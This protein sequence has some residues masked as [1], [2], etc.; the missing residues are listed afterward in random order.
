MLS[1]KK[2]N[3]LMFEIIIDHTLIISC[4]SNS[5]LLY[6]THNTL[7]S[8]LCY[9]RNI[10][11][12]PCILHTQAISIFYPYS[13]YLIIKWSWRTS[14][15]HW[16]GI[17]IQ[18]I[19]FTKFIIFDLIIIYIFIV[20]IFVFLILLPYMIKDFFNRSNTYFSLCDISS[21]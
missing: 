7:S 4:H 1:N 6:F 13:N 14:R 18:I 16:S 12:C 9:S 3:A 8:L 15:K 19:L 21:I 17:T 11:L 5:P 20:S 2:L 10:A